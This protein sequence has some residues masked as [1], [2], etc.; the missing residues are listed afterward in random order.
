MFQTFHRTP[1]FGQCRLVKSKSCAMNGESVDIR[2]NFLYFLNKLCISP[3]V[4]EDL[5]IS[6]VSH[7]TYPP[8]LKKKLSRE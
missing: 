4:I 8:A 6:K 1:A 3:E 7:N 2:H 5:G